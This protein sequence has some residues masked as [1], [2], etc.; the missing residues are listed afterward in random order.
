[1]KKGRR[2]GEK[3]VPF[4]K[5]QGR[6]KVGRGGGCGKGGGHA[7]EEKRKRSREDSVK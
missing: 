1:M 2:G 5:R 7:E 6:R 3:Y 4:F